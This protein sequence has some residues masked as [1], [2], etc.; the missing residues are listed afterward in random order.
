MMANKTTPNDNNV[1]DFIAG[2]P[3]EKKRNDAQALV[4]LMREVTGEEPTMWGDSI[5]GFGKYQY[6]YNSGRS[7]IWFPVGFSPRKANLTVYI[8]GG[9]ERQAALLAKLGKH[10][11]SGGSCV[12]IKKLADVD[13]GVLREL[14]AAAKAW[15]DAQDK[16]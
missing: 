4:A 11:V 16:P 5:V 15:G 6:E 2:I 9:S 7:D 8:S 1:A 10:S 14:V 13:M 12:Y 3:D